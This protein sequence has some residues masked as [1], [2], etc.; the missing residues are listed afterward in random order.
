MAEVLGTVASAISIGA[1]AGQIAS[2]VVKLKSY[3]DQVKD[4][5]DDVRNLIDEIDDLQILLSDIEDDRARN[6]YSEMLLQNNS[7]SRCLDHCR[8][9]VERLSR[10]VDKMEAD[11]QS[12]NPMKRRLNAVKMIWKRDQVEKYR[13]DLGS[14]VRLLSLSH[15]IYT[16]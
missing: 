12:L 15:Q 5:P 11:L 16:R 9:G 7:A 13:T 6:P 14:A 4:A 3:L 10:V 1:L 2:S 8:R